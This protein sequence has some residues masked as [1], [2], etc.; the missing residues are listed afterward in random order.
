MVP[1][2]SGELLGR[3]GEV[4]AASKEER[5]IAKVRYSITELQWLPTLRRALQLIDLGDRLVVAAPAQ[6]DEQQVAGAGHH[7]GPADVMVAV[8]AAE[9]AYG[10]PDAADLDVWRR[11]KV[12]VGGLRS[13]A[14]GVADFGPLHVRPT[15]AG[16]R[17]Q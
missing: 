7:V 2:D 16:A 13:A 8:A 9:P 14:V 15:S 6:D 11:P 10:A 5:V 3:K 12:E 17:W 4:F 1:P